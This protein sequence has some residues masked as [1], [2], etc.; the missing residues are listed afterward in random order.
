VTAIAYLLAQLQNA[1]LKLPPLKPAC[2]VKNVA[3]FTLTMEAMSSVFLMAN[4]QW[5][6]LSERDCNAR[7]EKTERS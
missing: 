1:Q 2:T 7:L 5:L 6:Q 4:I 3:K